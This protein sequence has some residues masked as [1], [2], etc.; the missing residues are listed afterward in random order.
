MICPSC[1]KEISNQAL[2]CPDCGHLF[3]SPKSKAATLVFLL[4]SIHRLYAGKLLSYFVYEA[5][6]IGGFI[7]MFIEPG[8]GAICLVSVVIWG[9]IDFFKI[10][11]GN[12]TDSAG[13]KIKN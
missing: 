1:N 12:F 8:F 7:S 11:T 9:A 3:V 13:L 2:S 10:V 6:V 4:F 5:L